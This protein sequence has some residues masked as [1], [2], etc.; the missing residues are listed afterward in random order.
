[1]ASY[2]HTPGANNQQQKSIS[3]T[4]EDG[5]L[6]DEFY[7]TMNKYRRN[8]RK[9]SFS[10][11]PPSTIKYRQRSRSRR[12]KSV[13]PS[14][15]D[16]NKYRRR[17]R[18]RGERIR[19]HGESRR[20]QQSE[21]PTHTRSDKYCG[22]GVNIPGKVIAIHNKMGWIYSNYKSRNQ[23]YSFNINNVATGS[24]RS[25]LD[26]DQHVFFN[27]NNISVNDIRPTIHLSYEQIKSYL[28]IDNLSNHSNDI[29]VSNTKINCHED[30]HNEFK[31]CRNGFHYDLLM[32]YL[33]GFVNSDG[34]SIY[35]GIN[36]DGIVKGVNYNNKQID[37]LLCKVDERLKQWA[38]KQYYDNLKR[39]VKIKFIK[40]IQFDDVNKIGYIIPNSVVIK[41]SI[42][43]ISGDS[44][45]IMFT[46]SYTNS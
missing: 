5:Q 32:K 27:H 43:T 7:E 16:R 9:R 24:N 17:L 39:S 38:P 34:G 1:M 45:Q 20:Y 25:L 22:F 44:N 8:A 46:D 40:L 12:R 4:M 29:Y 21:L 18:D 41:C 26:V 35:F 14:P 37:K 13:S 33:N 30:I 28:T 3:E 2:P 36:D 15:I 23:C 10:A 11:Q 19:Y 42:S 31:L 6:P